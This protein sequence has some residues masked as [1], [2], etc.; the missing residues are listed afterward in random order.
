MKA[1]LTLTAITTL[2]FGCLANAVESN[3][4]NSSINNIKEPSVVT[5]SSQDN[6]TNGA[7]VDPAT[8]TT[9]TEAEANDTQPMV[10][11]ATEGTTVSD[12]TTVEPTISTEEQNSKK[13]KTT[14]SGKKILDK[15]SKTN[16]N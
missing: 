13:P 8:A 15:F 1:I 3:D 10:D 16:K 6:N 11:P 7:T 12:K 9:T 4:I 2:S 14:S 5:P